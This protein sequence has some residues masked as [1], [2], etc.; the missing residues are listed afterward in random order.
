MLIE[1]ISTWGLK[2]L[3]NIFEFYIFETILFIEQN[4]LI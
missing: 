4:N 1:Q 3:K 2:K